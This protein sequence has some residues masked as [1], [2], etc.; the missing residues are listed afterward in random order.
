MSTAEN[1]KLAHKMI[2]MHADHQ[3]GWVDVCYHP[4]CVWTELPIGG[5]TEG[6]HGGID[7]LRT[8]AD[9]ACRIF[10][11]ISIQVTNTVGDGDRVALEIE[12][13][14]TMAQKR[15]SNGAARTAKLKMA[16]FLTFADGKIIRQ[17]DYPIPKS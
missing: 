10:P 12:F 7:S 4:N 16:I 2:E 1:I 5:Q 3:E 9:D 14:G 17:V 13:E 8:A 15:G 11:S 6:R